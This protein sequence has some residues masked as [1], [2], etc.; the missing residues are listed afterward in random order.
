MHYIVGL[1]NPGEEYEHTR[2]NVG[3]RVLRNFV[4]TNGLPSFHE[5]SSYSGEVSEGIFEGEEITILLP[6]TYMNASGTAIAKLVPKNELDK[7]LVIYD[8][9]DLP[10][11]ELKTS[12]G[13][14]DNGVRSII[15]KLGS[16]D[17][18]RLRVGISQKSFWSGKPVR[19]KGE[20][21]AKYV[22]TPFSKR[23][24]KE[25]LALAPTLKEMISVFITKGKD[26]L[27][28]RYN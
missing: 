20:A 27:M 28:N 9:V 14:G 8:E 12:F 17:F 3:F 19:P 18:T 15:E 24:E 1:G 11:G 26:A 7:L 21:L 6:H 5:S 10:L 23:E 4:E 2:H 16:K 13:R 22:L 25:F